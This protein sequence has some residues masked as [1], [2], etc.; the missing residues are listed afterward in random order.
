MVGGVGGESK[1]SLA[2]RNIVEARAAVV[3]GAKSV[4]RGTSKA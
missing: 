2:A 1:G 3:N 4:D